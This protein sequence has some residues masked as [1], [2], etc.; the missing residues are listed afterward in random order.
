MENSENR[1]NTEFSTSI[2]TMTKVDNLPLNKYYGNSGN[3]LKEEVKPSVVPIL[4]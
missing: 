4:L 3:L 2:N 1:F